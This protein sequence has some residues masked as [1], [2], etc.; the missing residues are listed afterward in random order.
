MEEAASKGHIPV[1][2]EPVLRHLTADRRGCYLDATFGGGGHSEGILEADPSNSVVALD[3]DPDA[4]KRAEA[5]IGK[6]AGRLRF[7][8]LNFEE[9]GSLEEGPFIGALFDLGV[10]SFHFDE[11]QRGFSFQ[12]E[13][14]LDM[15]MDPENGPSAATFLQRSS[16]D[17]LVEAIRGFGEEPRWRKVVAAIES[18][19]GTPALERT[20]AFAELVESAL[21]GRRPQDKIHPATRTFQGVRIAV[22]RELAVIE[23]AL[24]AAFGKLEPGGRLAVISFHSLEDRIV[25]RTFRRLAGR[26]EH[27]GDSRTQDQRQIEGRLLTSKPL[28]ADA[29][30]C[31]R[32]PRSRS[33][34][35]RI[36]EKEAA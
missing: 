4:Q 25:K 23:R 28:V 9:I 26:P 1:L 22:N 6:W 35:L 33:A 8:R 29:A 36:I 10:S 30:E 3:C 15:R 14:P 20:L 17:E 18:A 12:Q 27:R 34:K 19:R 16:Y 13:G 31:T 11:A 2:F 24:P 32:N 7:H 5:L 21:G